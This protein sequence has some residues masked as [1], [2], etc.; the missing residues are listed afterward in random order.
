M[1]NKPY[2]PL[3]M[4]DWLRGT[5][6]MRA[7]VRG[8]YLTL[9]IYQYDNGFVPADMDELCLIDPELPKVWVKIKDKFE[10]FEA[11]KLRNK[12]LEEVRD[13]WSKQSKNGKKGGRPKKEKP[14]NNP[15]INPET[16]PNLKLHIDLDPDIDL[17]LKLKESF[18]EIYI[19]GLR[20]PFRKKDI[21][22]ELIYFFQKVRGSPEEYEYRDGGGLKAAF[23]YQLRNAKDKQHARQSNK[24]SSSEF[25]SFDSVDYGAKL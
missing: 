17:E 19:E 18:N 7:E 16:N 2:M 25:K 14:N 24:G 8:V 9:L 1:A 5:K 10:E 23:E 13:F 3:M 15:N 12:K 21:D 22:Q 11:G 6:G 20:S 4:G